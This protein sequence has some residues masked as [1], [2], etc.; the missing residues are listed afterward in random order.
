MGFA[1]NLKQLRG[2]LKPLLSLLSFTTLRNF[3][4]GQFT[5][6]TISRSALNIHRFE[7]PFGRFPVRLKV[8]SFFPWERTEL[9]E[10]LFKINLFL[11]E[12]SLGLGK[13]DSPIQTNDSLKLLNLA[14]KI[15]R[16]PLKTF[17]SSYGKTFLPCNKTGAIKIAF[18][19]SNQQHKRNAKWAHALTRVIRQRRTDTPP[20]NQ[21]EAKFSCSSIEASLAHVNNVDTLWHVRL[22]HDVREKCCRFRRSTLEKQ[23]CR[24]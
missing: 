11:R 23:R 19:S 14:R 3:H 2:S 6:K 18:Q 10:N 4:A 5:T 8:A 21:A 22:S 20:S 24:Q 7:S 9:A 16:D 17:L 12:T 1:V 15:L 13:L